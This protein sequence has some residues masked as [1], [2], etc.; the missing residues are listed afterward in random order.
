MGFAW[1]ATMAACGG[2]PVP[3]LPETS[4]SGG[5]G[6]ASTSITG[7]STA[8]DVSSGVDFVVPPDGGVLTQCDLYADGCPEGEKCTPYASNGGVDRD[9]TKCISVAESPAQLDDACTVESW[10]A[11][12]LDDCARGL[13]CAVYDPI[14]LI[15]RCMAI[16]HADPDETDLVCFDPEARCVG[17]ID[18]LPRL[19]A[20][21]CDPFGVD[22]PEGQACYRIGDHFTCLDDVSGDG[23]DYGDR[24]LFTNDC[25]PAMLCADPPEF[26]ECPHLDGCCTPFCDTRLPDASAECPGAPEHECVGLFEPGEASPLY[27][28]VGACVVRSEDEG[29]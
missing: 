27:D 7:T 9:A 25:S 26:F 18:A 23:G 12:G 22:C 2:D 1:L 21:D 11:S 13:F 17:P 4:S 24:C 6:A 14:A 10:I 8:V 3:L 20:T 29:P 28:W 19:C 15:G 5:S 16:C